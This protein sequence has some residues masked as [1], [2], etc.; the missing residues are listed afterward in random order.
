[1]CYKVTVE[2][3]VHDAYKDADCIFMSPAFRSEA[4]AE[5]FAEGARAVYGELVAKGARLS[6]LAISV[7]CRLP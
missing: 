6:G 2:W 5:R 7:S 3:S 4:D 1:M